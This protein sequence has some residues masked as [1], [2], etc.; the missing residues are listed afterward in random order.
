[1]EDIKKKISTKSNLN[2][3]LNSKS[4]SLQTHIED[5]DA[6]FKNNEHLMSSKQHLFTPNNT[7]S[8]ATDNT[9]SNATEN[10]N[11]FFIKHGGNNKTQSNINEKPVVF[12]SDSTN[13]LCE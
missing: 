6:F 7:I 2:L 10:N 4:N 13:S 3:N 11:K 9:I 5:T 8:N 12:N 1:M